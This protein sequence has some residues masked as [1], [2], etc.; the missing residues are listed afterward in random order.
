MRKEF[1]DSVKETLNKKQ[2]EAF[3]AEHKNRQDLAIDK[4]KGIKKNIQTDKTDTDN[5]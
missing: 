3:K 5:E 2:Y 4:L 1:N